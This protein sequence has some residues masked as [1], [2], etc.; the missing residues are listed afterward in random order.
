MARGRGEAGPHPVDIAVGRR[1]AERRV[2]LGFNQSELG[3]ALDLTFQQVQ[4]YEKGSN[5]ISSSKLWAAANFL[6]V[7]I[8]YFFDGLPVEYPT[9]AAASEQD[10]QA[11][12][13]RH[14]LEIAKLVTGLSGAHQKLVLELVKG[15]R[16]ARPH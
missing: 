1:L 5:R 4:K 10:A 13:T 14:S 2:S 16:D 7:D 3:R 8:G 6:K 9:D 12:P 15:L 11:S